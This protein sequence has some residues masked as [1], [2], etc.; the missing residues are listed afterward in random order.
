MPSLSRFSFVARS[1]SGSEVGWN[2]RGSGV[3]E[4]VHQAANVRFFESGRFTLEGQDHDVPMRNVYRW[5]LHSDRVS[6]SH[7]RRGAAN[8]VSLFDLVA[9]DAETLVSAEVHQCAADAYSARLTLVPDGIDLEWRI[10]GPR[11]DEHIAYRYRS[12]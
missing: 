6:L 8:A 1:G 12:R 4:V 7:E 5:D 10:V 2:G 9:S 11:K 3:I